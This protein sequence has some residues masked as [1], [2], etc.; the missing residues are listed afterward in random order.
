M[1][2]SKQKLE[3]QGKKSARA[4]S[5]AVQKEEVRCQTPD[6]EEFT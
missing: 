2:L 3:S 5:R 1:K 6:A 4:E